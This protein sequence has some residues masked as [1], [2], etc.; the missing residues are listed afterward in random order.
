MLLK[1][2]R[3]FHISQCLESI[4]TIRDYIANIF[5]TKRYMLDQCYCWLVTGLK[6]LMSIHFYTCGWL[7]IHH[8]KKEQGIVAFEF[9]DTDITTEYVESL[10]L[11][12]TTASTVGYGDYSGRG[13][14]DPVWYLEMTYLIF[15]T[16][17]GIILF[18]SVANQIFTYQSLMTVNEM[19]N[20]R[21][22]SLEVYLY[23]ISAVISDLHMP[24]DLIAQC[25]RHVELS[26]RNSTKFH[27]KEN[28]FF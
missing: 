12:A 25:K 17:S 18:G 21:V 7:L 19:V 1:I 11:I 9:S 13:S 27:F 2:F 6:F 5:E 28:L 22:K 20:Q 14:E 3:L 4:E 8:Y 15:V 24:L 10:Y 26:I 23:E 16:I